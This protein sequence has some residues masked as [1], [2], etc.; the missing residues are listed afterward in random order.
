MIKINY[1][2]NGEERDQIGNNI[3]QKIKDL[4]NQDRSLEGND[5]ENLIKILGTD[6]K[7]FEKV[8]AEKWFKKAWFLISGK[9]GELTDISLNN[10]GKIQISVIKLFSELINDSN[11]FKKDFIATNYKIKMLD[12]DNVYMKQL[13]LEFNKKYADNFKQ[14]YS[15]LRITKS[16]L[17]NIIIGISLAFL[18]IN[19]IFI[20][21]E[22]IQKYNFAFAASLGF[23]TLFVIYSGSR[24][25]VSRK[26][27]GLGIPI[28]TNH[29]VKGNTDINM[30]KN[31]MKFLQLDCSKNGTYNIDVKNGDQEIKEKHK[32]EFDIKS[33]DQEY[34]DYFSLHEAEKKLLFSLEYHVTSEDITTTSEKVF[35]RKKEK[36]LGK[37]A[38]SINSTL[39]DPIVMEGKRLFKGLHEIKETSISKEKLLNMLFQVKIFTPY[40]KLSKRS[41]DL[42]LKFD[43]NIS[44]ASLGVICKTLN[45]DYNLVKET[46]GYYNQAIKDIPPF[47]SW[48]KF[49]VIA[50]SVILIALTGGAAAPFIGGIIGGVMGLSGAAAVSAGLA[51]LGGG[52]IA[53]G[54]LGMVGGTI[55]LIGGGAIL[56]SGLGSG[57]IKIFSNSKEF[58]LMELAKIDAI[59]KTYIKLIP[60]PKKYILYVIEKVLDMQSELKSISH[61]D[62]KNKNEI[63][64]SIE[65]CEREIVRLNE[66]LLKIS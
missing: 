49:Y 11:Q 61:K 40:Y 38:Q 8:K 2:L 7:K 45:F 20:I 56:G 30:I 1:E 37:W 33:E 35:Q 17:R 34:I 28:R 26:K 9:K 36:W 4:K 53:A 23:M 62:K 31:T 39:N 14:I 5:L 65:Y 42:E 15:E 52:A 51:F 46:E 13:I 60:I 32:L 19:S 59:S 41:K 25:I 55:A 47:W 64:K 63:F 22:I 57:F 21:P 50:A 66:L 3:Q 12:I 43:N 58:T 54:G 16:I 24:L 10:L 44:D 6:S 29:N 48:S 27:A 18:I